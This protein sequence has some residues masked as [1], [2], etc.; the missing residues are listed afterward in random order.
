MGVSM[1]TNIDGHFVPFSV[2][3]L[4][5]LGVLG[6]LEPVAAVSNAASKEY[7]LEKALEKMR[8]DWDGLAFK[9]GD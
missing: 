8:S 7:S 2:R 9:V 6:K 1:D 3:M 4:L 5:Q